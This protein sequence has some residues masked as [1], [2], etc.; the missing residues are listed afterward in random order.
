M[1][2]LRN[3][4]FDLPPSALKAADVVSKR[5][6]RVSTRKYVLVQ[7]K[8]PD[9]VLV[10]PRL[11]QTRELDVHRTVIL[12]HIIALTE[13]RRESAN[14]HM[15]THLDLGNLVEFP[16]RDI[17]V[18]HTQD[19]AL[20]LGDTRAAEGVVAPGGLV[21]GKGSARDMRAVVDAGKLSEGA[22]A[23]TDIQK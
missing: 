21:S 16:C 6:G 17:T 9:E 2:Q 20:T 7:E 1:K 18:V 4:P 10:L 3:L 5:S 11:A 12:K 13:E 15:L 19:V 22:P 8:P 23:A 14:T